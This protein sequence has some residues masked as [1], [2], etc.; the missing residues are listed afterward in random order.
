MHGS[1]RLK[2]SDFNIKEKAHWCLEAVADAGKEW[3][4]SIESSPFI[5]GRSD[6][7]NL[8]LI[9]K[10]IS[11][12]H[13]EMRMGGDLLWIRDLGSTNG[14]F[15]NHK[16]IE[17]AE[18][19]EPDDIISIG[20]YAFRV[21]REHPLSSA[22]SN[23]TLF[24]TLS[25]ELKDVSSFESK[26]RALIDERNVIPHFQPLVRFSDMSEFGYEILGRAGDIDLP[27]N[28]SELLDIAEFLG[29]AA[30][31]S[32][33][34]REVGVEIGKKLPGSPFL[35]VNTTKVELYEIDAL[36]ASLQRIRDIA[37]SNKIVLEI[38]EKAAADNSGLPK[39]CDA[40]KEMG[41]ALAFDDFGVG[42]TRLKALSTTSPDYLKFDL[43][44]IRHIHLAPE[45]LRQMISTFIKA[46]HDLGI[47]TLAEG[48]ECSEEARVCQQLGF[49][50]GQ[51]FLFG[52]PAP[53]RA[54]EI[55]LS[56][57]KSILNTL[58]VQD[59]KI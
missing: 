4:V 8:K 6:D 24:A 39:L 2:T 36:L 50:F 47:S 27:S 44:L 38:N 30:D 31:L 45:R 48:I 37:P 23:E 51:G 3:L 19:L 9:D 7:C 11:R 25:E 15:L 41:M 29:C 49:D 40:L 58:R 14:T 10:R 46:A 22:A 13:G 32:A 21:K 43:S 16:K 52:R 59:A 18:L 34:F 55:S 12:H 42:Q 28:P 54:I 26:L 35:F 33:L 20:N 56:R 5:I 53:F 1:L 57:S 17:H